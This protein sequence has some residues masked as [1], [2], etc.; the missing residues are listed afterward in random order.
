MFDLLWEVFESE[1]AMVQPA[2]FWS[3]SPIGLLLAKKSFEVLFC[4]LFQKRLFLVKQDWRYSLQQTHPTRLD[5]LLVLSSAKRQKLWSKVL[6]NHRISIMYV[7]D[8]F[9]WHLRHLRVESLQEQ[10]MDDKN[11]KLCFWT[12]I[13][14]NI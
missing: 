9:L 11:V 3:S 8:V 14:R 12:L 10:K 2:A 13:L 5:K 1:T 4:K 7:L 6:L